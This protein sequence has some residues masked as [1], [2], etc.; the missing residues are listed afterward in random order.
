M[1][2]RPRERADGGAHGDLTFARRGAT[3]QE[4]G[5]VGACDEQ[6]GRDACED[7]EEE[8]AVVAE[9]GVGERFGRETD[10]R[11]GNGI[12]P[13]QVGRRSCQRGVRGSEGRAVRKPG[14]RIEAVIATIVSRAPAVVRDERPEIGR[15]EAGTESLGRRL[16]HH[17]GRDADDAKRHAVDAHERADGAGC[18]VQRGAPESLGDH[19]DARRSGPC[20][21]RAR[22]AAEQRP[23]PEHGEELRRRN[24]FVDPAWAPDTRH[25]RRRW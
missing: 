10:V 4:V 25:R 13:V 17:V 24:D 21:G 5:D 7:R 12:A 15:L 23:D 19:G 18:R 9:H 11:V 22:E 1:T 2:M 16:T 14:D 3:Q 8:R 6:H 20:I